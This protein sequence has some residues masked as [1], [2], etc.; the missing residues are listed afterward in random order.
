MDDTHNRVSLLNHEFLKGVVHSKTVGLIT[1]YSSTGML[2]IKVC[3]LILWTSEL[4][5][6]GVIE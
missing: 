4:L 1:H 5:K 6:V 3:T 2:D